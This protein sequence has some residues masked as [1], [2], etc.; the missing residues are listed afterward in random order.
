MG[1]DI[2]EIVLENYKGEDYI[3][4]F[5]DY[6]IAKKNFNHLWNLNKDMPE[7]KINRNE[8]EMS[9]YDCHYNEYNT[10]VYLFQGG[11]EIHNKIIF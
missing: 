9:W 5:E 11:P 10:F 6:E 8:N 7:F 3:T 1:N 2:W 4:Y